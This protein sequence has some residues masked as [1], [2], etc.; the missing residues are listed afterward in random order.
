MYRL[1]RD[2]VVRLPRVPSA[3][4]NVDVEHRWFPRLS[5]VLPVAIPVPLGRGVPGRSAVTG[6]CIAGSTAT[7]PR[8]S[9]SSIYLM[10]PR[11]GRFVAAL[12]RFDGT[13]G[14]PSFRGGPIGARDG[15]LSATIRALEADGTAD[16]AVATAWLEV[17]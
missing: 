3:A 10:R 6:R 5:P 11:L 8:T 15:D 14:P 16:A 17:G 9:P 12:H 4:R 7:T 2:M 1:G 13:G